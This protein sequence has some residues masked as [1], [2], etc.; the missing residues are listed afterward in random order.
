MVNEYSVRRAGTDDISAMLSLIGKC[1]GNNS[2]PCNADHWRWKH[3]TN[4]FGPSPC[5]VAEA[6][7]VLVG[8]RA[9]MRWTWRHAGRNV[10]TVRAVDTATDPAWRRKGIFKTLTMQL[11]TEMQGEGV[12]LVFN[13]PNANSHPGYLNM[14]WRSIG[15]SELWVRPLRPFRL[16]L[17]LRN[18]QQA[19]GSR[20]EAMPESMADLPTV[21][22]VLDQSDFQA[23]LDAQPSDGA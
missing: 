3:S 2:L 11:A 22:S 23:L 6:D 20:R 17:G 10:K 13:T 4:P 18:R 21:G 1:L 12:N 8:L 5:L 16:A 14:G 15:R 7:G 19:N 9:F